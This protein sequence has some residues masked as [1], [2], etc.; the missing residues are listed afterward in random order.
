MKQQSKT[1]LEEDMEIICKDC[2]SVRI[3]NVKELDYYDTHDFPYPRRC[4]NCINKRR[5]YVPGHIDC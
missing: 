4:K 5:K 2:G 3:F 1:I